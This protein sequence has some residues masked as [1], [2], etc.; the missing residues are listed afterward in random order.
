M[1]TGTKGMVSQ[2]LLPV[3]W[4]SPKGI[5]SSSKQT[6]KITSAVR[7]SDIKSTSMDET[8]A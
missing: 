7:C 8:M 6:L 3:L 2:L 5:N 4:S 1:L